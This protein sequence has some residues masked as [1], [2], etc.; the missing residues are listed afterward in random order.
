MKIKSTLIE[1]AFCAHIIGDNAF[2]S[3]ETTL[4][5]N[6]DDTAMSEQQGDHLCLFRIS[7]IINLAFC[8]FVRW[9]R[10]SN[11]QNLV[12]LFSQFYHLFE[13]ELFHLLELTFA[14]LQSQQLATL[15]RRVSHTYRKESA[16]CS[17]FHINEHK[18]DSIK[19][20]I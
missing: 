5:Y 8:D 7:M 19:P 14:G 15:L 1:I 6:A 18:L 9:F 16:I 13:N 12:Y 20:R 4:Y 2:G 11:S 10:K 17:S 3:C